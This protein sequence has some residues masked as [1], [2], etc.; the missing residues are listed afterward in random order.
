[1]KTH[2]VAGTR[3]KMLLRDKGRMGGL[4][5]EVIIG[6]RVHLHGLGGNTC[7][8]DPSHRRENLRYTTVG[9]QDS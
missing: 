6:Q 3:W 5:E 4:V 2:V 8:L 1:M 9:K 7:L